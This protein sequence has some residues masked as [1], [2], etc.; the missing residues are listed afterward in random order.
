MQRGDIVVCSL[1]GDYGKIRPAVII[2]SE[3]FNVTHASIVIAPITSHLVDAPLFR[4]DLT[5]NS[6]NGLQHPSQIMVDKIAA[7]KRDRLKKKIGELR[8]DNVD[9]LNNALRLW[10]D[11]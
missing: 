7:I 8:N 5:P 6:D 3:L 4:L 11:L 1:S 10:L 2:Q 9:M